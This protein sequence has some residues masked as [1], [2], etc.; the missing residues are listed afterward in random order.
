MR[1]TFCQIYEIVTIIIIASDRMFSPLYGESGTAS[2]SPGFR[3][4]RADRH[5]PGCAFPSTRR[6]KITRTAP[7]ERSTLKERVLR[8][9][10]DNDRYY[11]HLSNLFSRNFIYDLRRLRF[12][13]H[14]RLYNVRIQLR[15][16][17]SFLQMQHPILDLLRPA[18]VPE[19]GTDIAA[20]TAGDIEL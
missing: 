12:V 1:K 13:K 5:Q 7:P 10:G 18:L 16:C 17:C 9:F 3:R 15:T 2:G 8:A 11:P 14:S 4:N 19:L 6:E 20:G